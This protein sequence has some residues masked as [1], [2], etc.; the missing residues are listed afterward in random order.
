MP[1]QRIPRG[2][3]G[4]QEEHWGVR[5]L[6]AGSGGSCQRSSRERRASLTLPLD[7]GHFG[8]TRPLKSNEGGFLP[9]KG[10]R[11]PFPSS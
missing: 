9:A 3:E 4:H 1:G 2:A 6:F 8:L 10:E 11:R 5:K 7:S